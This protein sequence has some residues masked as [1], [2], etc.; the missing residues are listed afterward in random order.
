MLV[1]SPGYP[2]LL[3]PK[4]DYQVICLERVMACG[5]IIPSLLVS[6]T[7]FNF[8]NCI[9]KFS[10]TNLNA[11]PTLNTKTHKSEA[12][13]LTDEYNRPLRHF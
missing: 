7:L 1:A 3:S 4:K 8:I 5:R 13:T 12:M 10:K 6:L 2:V 11:E 9:S